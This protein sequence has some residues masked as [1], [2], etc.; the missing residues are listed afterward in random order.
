[1][2][3]GADSND[4]VTVTTVTHGS[5]LEPKIGSVLAQ[6]SRSASQPSLLSIF[7]LHDY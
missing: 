7:R 3:R 5:E 2:T 4:T 1:M 6:S